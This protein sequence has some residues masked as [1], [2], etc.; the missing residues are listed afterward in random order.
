MCV[1]VCVCV[2][3]GEGGEISPDFHTALLASGLC[4]HS[5]R[6]QG[7]QETE[8]VWGASASDDESS[9]SSDDAGGGQQEV[10]TEQEEEEEESE[11]TGLKKYVESR[12]A[13]EATTEKAVDHPPGGS[14][15]APRG[16]T[17]GLVVNTGWGG[18]EEATM[19]KGV[20][21][22]ASATTVVTAGILTN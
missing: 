8:G 4:V 7:G 11:V 19:E 21:R 18:T 10:G 2:C 16:T 15:V 17:K 12:N 6:S 20:N 5:Q 1:C 14:R 13:A 9:S 22:T 3:E